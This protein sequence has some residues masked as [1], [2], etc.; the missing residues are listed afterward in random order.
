MNELL[1]KLLIIIGYTELHVQTRTQMSKTYLDVT[2][3][4]IPSLYKQNRSYRVSGYTFIY[5][6]YLS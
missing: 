4:Y 6:I 5:F 2:L 1:R 3:P